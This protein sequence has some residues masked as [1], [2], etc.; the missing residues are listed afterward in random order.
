[1]NTMSEYYPI[2]FIQGQ[3]T[4]AALRTPVRMG[5]ESDLDVG[6]HVKIRPTLDRVSPKALPAA[7]F[8]QSTHSSSAST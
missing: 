5:P 2:P 4:R 3:I 8:R 1:M 7:S 6:K